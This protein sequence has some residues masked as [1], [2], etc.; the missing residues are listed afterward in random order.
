MAD[1]EF[2]PPSLT[3]QVSDTDLAIGGKNPAIT[4]VEYGDYSCRH[5]AHFFEIIRQILMEYGNSVKFVFRHFP[6]TTIHP[7][8]RR[9]AIAAEAAADQ[10]RFWEMHET[11][12]ENQNDLSDEGILRAAESIDGLDMERFREDFTSDK[13][14][15]KI[16]SDF[17][18][19]LNSGVNGTPTIFIDGKRYD[20]AW[21]YASIVEFIERPGG[22]KLELLAQR[23]TQQAVSGGILLF[24]F[25]ILGLIL[26]NSPVAT[27]YFSFL[28][29]YLDLS[30]G[31]TAILHKSMIHIINDGL[32]AIFFL[33]VG[34]EIKR[35]VLTGELSNFN[36]AVL[37]IIAAM[38]GAIIPVFLYLL[39]NIGNPTAM[40][41][42]GIAM[43]T[44]IAF[45]LVIFTFL[46]DR[47]PSSLR[48][49]FGA[50]AIVDDILAILV[51]S[52]FYTES[53]ELIPLIFAG[54][55][56][57]V[58]IVMNR[59]KIYAR[60]PYMI[61]GILLWYTILL[62]GVHATLAGVLLAFTIPTRTAPN[63][64]ALIAQ[65]SNLLQ[66]FSMPNKNK[67]EMQHAALQ[68]METITHRLQSPL[69]SLEH[70]VQPWT[71][72]LILPIFAL[73]NAG[74][75]LAGFQLS[76]LVNSITLGIIVGLVIGKPLGILG[77]SW[78]AIKL[79]W[80]ELPTGV[81]WSNFF[82]VSW[83]AG[84]GFTMSLFISNLAFT[85]DLLISEAKIG[86]LI[87]SILASI[88]GL[89][90][91]FKMNSKI[92][93]EKTDFA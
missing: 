49:F 12:Y 32:M 48:V 82:S 16:N 1:S 42:Y 7:H 23:F 86:I 24:F 44:D 78:I 83:L 72:Y 25:T 61:F 33:L 63:T 69:E 30:V 41:G 52:V 73:A 47:V 2:I 20:G 60:L 27:P 80:A 62:S 45:L 64:R 10:D 88:I 40:S 29:S 28:D 15:D 37:P 57:F 92:Y 90:L 89:S 70:D 81:G 3:E 34:L 43:A 50:L 84:I 58:L 59:A 11:L 67:D 71:T 17:E 66:D 8:A 55:F 93:N 79:G 5:C 77:F 26:A 13:Y 36:K 87:A 85:D 38:G 4:I 65:A 91:G 76:T 51:I 39:I 56:L 22:V 6:I 21:D 68:T 14:E 54:I 35:E 18:E 46:Q 9:A 75:S 31:T 19:G 53:L 74:I